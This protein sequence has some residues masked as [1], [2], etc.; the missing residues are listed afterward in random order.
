MF[1]FIAFNIVTLNTKN[2]IANTPHMANTDK[3][4]APENPGIKNPT[5]EEANKIFA[6]SAQN[7]EIDSIC[8]GFNFDCIKP[9]YHIDFLSQ[10]KKPLIERPV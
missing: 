9:H 3:V 7:L 8:I 1:Y 6:K 5:T 2:P 10:T 4:T